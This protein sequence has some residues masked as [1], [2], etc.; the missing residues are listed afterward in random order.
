[1]TIILIIKKRLQECLAF[2]E[3]RNEKITL[4]LGKLDRLCSN[5]TDINK[6]DKLVK[7]YKITLDFIDIGRLDSELNLE[8]KAYYKMAMVLANIYTNA[9]SSAAKQGHINRKLKNT[10]SN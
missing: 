6:I 2:I 4:V 5:F 1:M 3:A 10:N 8:Q 7:K 9:R